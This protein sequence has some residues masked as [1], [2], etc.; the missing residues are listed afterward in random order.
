M[1]KMLANAKTKKL[2]LYL[3]LGLVLNNRLFE[4]N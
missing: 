2:I 3:M 4:L 1:S